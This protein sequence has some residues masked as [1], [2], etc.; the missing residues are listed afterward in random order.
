MVSQEPTAEG[1]GSEQERLCYGL[2]VSPQIHVSST[3]TVLQNMNLFGNKVYRGNQAKVR[4]WDG[5]QPHVTGVLINRGH[6]DPEICLKERQRKR[7]RRRVQA[8]RGGAGTVP[9]T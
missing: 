2:N 4:S 6:V 7:R 3:P 8:R 5:P 9:D 1:D